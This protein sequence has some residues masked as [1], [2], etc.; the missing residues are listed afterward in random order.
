MH[1]AVNIHFSVASL[2]M[3]YNIIA[4]NKQVYFVNI[5]NTFY[6]YLSTSNF[7]IKVFIRFLFLYSF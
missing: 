3:K 6:L 2:Y 4:I 1:L 5:E 7:K